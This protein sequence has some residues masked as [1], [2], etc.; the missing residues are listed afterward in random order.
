MITSWNI[1]PNLPPNIRLH[2]QFSMHSPY[3]EL[4]CRI[5]DPD[6]LLTDVVCDNNAG[7]INLNCRWCQQPMIYP[8]DLLISWLIAADKFELKLTLD[9]I[10]DEKF[11]TPQQIRFN[12][13]N[14]SCSRPPPFHL[15][16]K[17]FQKNILWPNS[18]QTVSNFTAKK[19]LTWC[20]SHEWK[21]FSITTVKKILH[22]P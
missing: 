3:V 19:T 9:W 4:F 20:S 22:F 21:L 11:H 10:W 7:L 15:P 8:L 17:W 18:T 1:L 6:W 12:Q 16:T 13:R 14:R 2:I 5:S